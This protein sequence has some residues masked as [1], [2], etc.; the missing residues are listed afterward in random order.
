ME[1]VQAETHFDGALRTADDTKVS[2][3]QLKEEL[4]DLARLGRSEAY[5]ALSAFR[6]SAQVRVVL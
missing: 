5:V 2:G 6:A 1:I 3:G 4:G